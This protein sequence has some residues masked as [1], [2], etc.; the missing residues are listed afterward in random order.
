MVMKPSTI[1][2]DTPHV[3]EWL[4]ILRDPESKKLRNKLQ[5]STIETKRCCL[6]HLCYIVGAKVIEPDS[7]TSYLIYH[8]KKDW[9]SAT[10]P[11]DLYME[12]D[13]TP[14]VHFIEPI[15]YKEHTNITSLGKLNDKTAITL[16]EIADIIEENIKNKN[17]RSY[18]S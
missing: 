3:A 12:L 11:I 7:K 1:S 10:L 6:G 17:F 4:S 15:T 8:Y 16:P 13:I 18:R 5:S 9:S 14:I 2:L